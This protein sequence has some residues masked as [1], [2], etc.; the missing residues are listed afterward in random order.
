MTNE[1]GAV[2]PA[3][4]HFRPESPSH[5]KEVAKNLAWLLERPV[6][7]CQE[8]LARIY[9]YSGLHELQ[10]VLKS[11]GTPGP[12]APRYN[13]LSSDKEA[14]V[15]KQ[16]QR[17]F[18]FLFGEPKGYWRDYFLAEDKCFLVFEMGL[19]Q[20][21][22]EHRACFEKIREVVTYGGPLGSWPLIHGW[23]LGLKSWLAS[24]YT[25]PLDLAE[26]WQKVLPTSRYA[27]MAYADIRWQ[28]RMT[29]LVRLATMFQLLAP[30]V[31][32]RK[33][34]CMEKIAFDQ[35]ETEGDGLLEP[36]WEEYCLAEWLTQKLSQKA[37]FEAPSPEIQAFIQRP[38]RSTAAACGFVKDLSDPVGFRDR[39]AFESFKAA[40][41]KPGDGEKT[42][43]SSNQDDRAIQSLFLYMNYESADISEWYDCDLWQFSCTRSE[44][45]EPVNA[46]SRPT[47]Q[48][49]IHANGS[50]IE[51]LDEDLVVMSPEDWYFC[52]DASGFASEA[53]AVAFGTLY[54]PAIGVNELDFAYRR[55]PY[56]I[57]EIDELLVA[58][59]VS[60]E[61]LKAYFVQLA[62]AF[63]DNCLP[64]SYGSWC[65]TLS[66]TLEDEDA[67]E[68]RDENGE[69][70]YY[71]YGPS[72]LLINI[73]GCGLTFVEAAHQNG[74]L[75]STLKHDASKKRTPGGEALAKR[76]MEAVKE[77]EVDIVIYDSGK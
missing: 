72:V 21:A 10:Q 69:Y 63:D 75:V 15:E 46:R 42:L 61:A 41:D 39:W 55:T 49:V 7:K 56:S 68:K 6:Q 48:P 2:A 19:F 1:A 30:R 59:S 16:D 17:I 24:G 11:L 23:P 31:D 58:S 43:F 73:P 53:A 8:D 3:D 52:H 37:E 29:G 51:P 12:F 70:G 71:V 27:S 76:V 38:S 25:E 74:Q 33:P 54:Q 65:K 35:F 34:R 13:Y 18:Y 9:G 22:A 44:V 32:G 64:D 45:I 26:G 40:L 60:T 77:L 4:G 62:N 57:I 50:L 5:F 47:L 66:L 36:A 28:R 14:L 20:E 67:N